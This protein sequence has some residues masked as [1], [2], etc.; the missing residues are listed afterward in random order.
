MEIWDAYSSDFEITDG[1][2]LVRGEEASIPAGVY[3]LVCNVLVRHTDG[4]YLLMQRDLR[5]PYAG[6]WEATAGGS[7]LK[8]ETPV[9]CARRELMEET[10]ITAGVTEEI[11]R[12]VWEPTHC[13]YADFLCITD[14]DKDS[15]VL[16]EGETIAYRWAAADEIRRMSSKELL[17]ERMRQYISRTSGELKLVFPTMEYKDRAVDYINEFY[18]YGSEI[19]GSGALDRFLKES[20]YEKWLE[21]LLYY[22]DIANIPAPGVPALTYFLVRTEDERIVGMVNIRLALN[23]FLRKEGGH[24]GY[25]VRPTERRKNYGTDMLSMALKVC[26]TIGIK[27]VLVS[28]DKENPASAGVIKKCGGILRDEFHSDTFDEML[29]MY[30]IRL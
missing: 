22:V 15:I 7:A 5:K 25:S 6:M 12:T 16:Q 26:D 27:E 8:G 21:K 20:T 11:R 28:C 17:S 18:E 24:I 10:G 14:C 23:D 4:T 30:A 19:N 3:H 13:L 1:M 29:Q 9:E 2:T